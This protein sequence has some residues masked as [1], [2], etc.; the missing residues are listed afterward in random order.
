MFYEFKPSILYY[1]RLAKC[2]QIIILLHILS[3]IVRLV[4]FCSYL[5]IL[6]SRDNAVVQGNVVQMM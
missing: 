2:T 5:F 3:E 1:F 4:R 6:V